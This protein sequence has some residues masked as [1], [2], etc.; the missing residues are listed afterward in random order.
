MLLYRYKKRK[1]RIMAYKFYYTGY[2]YPTK[3]E[4]ENTDSG[5][6][7]IVF[8]PLE[9]METAWLDKL[10]IRVEVLK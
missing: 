10:D 8:L 9:Y 7:E 3:K 1:E 5:V 2:G 4:I 6:F